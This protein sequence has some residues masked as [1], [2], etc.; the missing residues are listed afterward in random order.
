MSIYDEEDVY[1]NVRKILAV[2]EEPIKTQVLALLE[3]AERGEKTDNL[4]LQLVTSAGEYPRAWL[5]LA[6]LDELGDA[7]RGTLSLNL[8]LPGDPPSIPA[9]SV[10]VCPIPGCD[11]DYYV[12]HVRKMVPPCPIHNVALVR[13]P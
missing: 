7:D 1:Y 10:W 9:G 6:L 13:K 11:H 5:R 2:L 12:R 8:N 3:R 4:L